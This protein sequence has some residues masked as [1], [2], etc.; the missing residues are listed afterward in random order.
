MARFPDIQFSQSVIVQPMT[1]IKITAVSVTYF[2]KADEY[3]DVTL[4]DGC[5]RILMYHARIDAGNWM[6]AHDC[7]LPRCQEQ[8]HTLIQQTRTTWM[9]WQSLGSRLQTRCY[10]AYGSVSVTFRHGSSPIH[11][12]CQKPHPRLWKGDLTRKAQALEFGAQRAKRHNI[13]ACSFKLIP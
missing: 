9:D 11:R 7:D 10:K 4:R 13:H 8:C 2:R 12:N 5:E 6:H 1:N 3:H